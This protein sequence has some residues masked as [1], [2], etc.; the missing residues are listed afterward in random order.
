MSCLI[1]FLLKNPISKTGLISDDWDK[2]GVSQSETS[3]SGFAIKLSMIMLD[4]KLVL[5]LLVVLAAFTNGK[6]T[7]T[8]P[9]TGNNN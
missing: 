3:Q 6:P 1:E 8:T 5:V 4:I 7:E 9:N 2:N